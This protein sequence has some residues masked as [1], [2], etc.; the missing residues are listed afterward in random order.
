MDRAR[1]MLISAGIGAGLMYFFDP[2]GGRRRR[3]QLR[4]QAQRA[5][6]NTQTALDAAQDVSG[7]ARGVGASIRSRFR[8]ETLSDDAL[9]R[10]VRAIVE[11]AAS[12]PG[13][14]DVAVRDGG[15]ILSGPALAGE[16]PLLVDRVYDVRG[17]QD[18]KNQLQP[19]TEARAEA[20]YMPAPS[21]TG[22]PA[23]AGD[24]RGSES[25][26][27]SSAQR[28]AAG[29]GGAAVALYG[30]ARG[31]FIPRALAWSGIALAARAATNLDLKRLTGVGAR[32]RAVDIQKSVRIN[33]PIERVFESW[34]TCESYPH[35][36]THVRKVRRLED[37]PTNRRW[38]WTVCG[39][40]GSEFEFDTG[41]NVYEPKRVIGWRT[42]P[43]ALLQHAGIVR[44][45]EEPNG[46][47]RADVQMAYNPVAGAVGHVIAKL[48]GSDAKSQI[49]DDLDRMKSYIESGKQ[50][51]NAAQAT[52]RPPV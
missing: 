5:S 17:V 15:V 49:D 45:T 6:R 36:M 20:G 14:I 48:F 34:A 9:K 46:T 31:G 26:E 29:V 47:T 35:F 37:G 43:G 40:A 38:R 25:S 27:W 50:P 39:P 4:G 22:E 2:D 41:I 1:A 10:R 52:Q 33:A 8:P 7:R 44:F 21:G 3:A 11:R 24:S 19:Q 28:L 30:L 51:P 16:I 23:G 13:S 18:V 42:E 12:Q 32:R